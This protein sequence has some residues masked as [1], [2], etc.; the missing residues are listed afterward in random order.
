MSV[1]NGTLTGAL[2]VAVVQSSATLNTGVWNN[3]VMRYEME[4]KWCIYYVTS[5]Y[6]KKKSSVKDYSISGRLEHSLSLI[7]STQ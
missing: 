4:S 3:F 6:L 5:I 2:G 1:E 7:I